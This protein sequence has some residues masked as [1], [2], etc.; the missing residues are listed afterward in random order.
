M[1]VG[2]L[3]DL[4][5]DVVVK[6]CVASMLRLRDFR[7]DDCGRVEGIFFEGRA[8]ILFTGRKRVERIVVNV[9]VLFDVVVV[10]EMRR[11]HRSNVG[12]HRV[13]VVERLVRQSLVGVTFVA[14]G[15]VCISSFVDVEV[16]VWIV[17]VVFNVVVGD[18]FL[19]DVDRFVQKGRL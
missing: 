4:C 16:R 17:G 9:I 5:V 1:N 13:N 12:R 8:V 19:C 11:R 15:K 3:L 18:I 2:R 14:R 10:I 7:N 6:V